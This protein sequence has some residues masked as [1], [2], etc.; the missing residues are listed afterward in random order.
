MNCYPSTD[1]RGIEASFSIERILGRLKEGRPKKDGTCKKVDYATPDD[2][3]QVFHDHLDNLYTLSLLLTADRH[4]ADQCFVSGL[5]DC[6]EG[7]PVFREWAQSWAR[8]TVIKNAIRMISPLRHE[9]ETTA[10]IPEPFSEA[11]TPIAAITSLE[12]LDRFVYVLSVLER[13][14]DGECSI[15]LGCTVAR[16][17]DARIRALQAPGSVGSRK[18]AAKPAL[19]TVAP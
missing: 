18:G 10:G 11:D 5:D 2:F 8:R 17:L 14:S 9:T 7:N 3:C 1:C 16:V 15:L 19:T 12:P 6:L 4:K 13:Y